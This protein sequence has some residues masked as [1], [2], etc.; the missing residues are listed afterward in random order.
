M[1][2]RRGAYRVLA[3]RPEE[4]RQ[5]GISTH[6]W[7]NN[8]KTDLQYVR[9]SHGLDCSGSSHVFKNV[10]KSLKKARHA[11]W[12]VNENESRNAKFVQNNIATKGM[13]IMIP[14]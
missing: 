5:L 2:A 7:K 3:G 8:F 10:S 13:S 6:R 11:M 1:G 4:R 12:Y 14:D 9:W